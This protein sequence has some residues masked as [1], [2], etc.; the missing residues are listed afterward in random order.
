M[1]GIVPRGTVSKNLNAMPTVLLELELLLRLDVKSDPLLILPFNPFLFFNFKELQ[2]LLAR[3]DST[4]ISESTSE[5]SLSLMVSK[6]FL[7]CSG[8][9]SSL[10]RS[11]AT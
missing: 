2:R 4:N 11:E 9:S 10:V 1:G 6:N 7:M 8:V 5:L 3:E